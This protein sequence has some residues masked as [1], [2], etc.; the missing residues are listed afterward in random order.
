MPLFWPAT[1]PRRL[2]LFDLDNTLLAGDSDHAFGEFLIR[3]RLV[4]DAD[5]HRRKNDEFYED[6][7]RNRLN[8]EAY[9]AFTL[10]PIL[11]LDQPGREKLQ[12]E[13][14]AE[15]LSTMVPTAAM[16]LVDKHRDDFDYCV[17][18]TATNS[19]ITTPIANSFKVDLLLATETEE[20]NGKLTGRIRGIPC[21]REG[22]VLRLEEWLKSASSPQS[23]SLEGSI[24]YSDSSN[25]LPLLELVAE[26]V[27]VNGDAR[28]SAIATERGWRQL[29]LHQ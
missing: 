17:I 13:F 15:V 19:F 16:E 5:A 2:A 12:A 11:H 22:K 23:L 4:D 6:Y 18:I 8:I 9:V 26:P 7:R 21:Y 10:G 1:M 14:T 24:F 25:D 28:L 20:S 27:V 3:K 29:S